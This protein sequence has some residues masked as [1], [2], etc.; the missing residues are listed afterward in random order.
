MADCVDSLDWARAADL[1]SDFKKI[2]YN[3]KIEIKKTASIINTL[4]KKHY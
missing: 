3:E 4:I 1:T 2:P